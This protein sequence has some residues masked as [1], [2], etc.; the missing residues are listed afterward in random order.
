MKNT[1]NQ[2]FAVVALAQTATITAKAA[3]E[4]HFPVWAS[5][6]IQWFSLAL[7]ILFVT[8]GTRWLYYKLIWRLWHSRIDLNGK[9]N[10]C[11]S[12]KPSF[13]SATAA[14]LIQENAAFHE[15]VSS[16]LLVEQGSHG[17]LKYEQDLDGIEMHEVI[18]PG[19]TSDSRGRT[20]TIEFD[21]KRRLQ[22]LIEVIAMAEP[23][24][25][26]EKAPG[27]VGAYFTYLQMESIEVCE[28]ERWLYF[29][30]RPSMMV[31]TFSTALMTPGQLSEARLVRPQWT[32]TI[33]T[34]I[35]RRI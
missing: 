6:G 28:W 9:W 19:K 31:G 2:M 7:L 20:L 13:A 15:Q 27:C 8:L 29:L 3:L 18:E 17:T 26:A 12:Y 34:T 35:Y 25:T 24:R 5:E 33:G 16:L 22:V 10:F 14:Q 1:R 4:E 11:T 23:Q 32:P 21:E 30:R